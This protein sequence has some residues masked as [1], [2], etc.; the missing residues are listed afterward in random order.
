LID[1]VLE[2][3]LAVVGESRVVVTAD[4]LEIVRQTES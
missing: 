4:D 2:T 3:P 1:H